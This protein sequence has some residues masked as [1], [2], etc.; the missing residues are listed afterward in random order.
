MAISSRTISPWAPMQD[1]SIHCD[2][3]RSPTGVEEKQGSG[4]L[5]GK[6]GLVHKGGQVYKDLCCFSLEATSRATFVMSPLE[7]IPWKTKLVTPA[8]CSPTGEITGH[9]ESTLAQIAEKDNNN[10][11]TA[12]EA[13]PY[14]ENDK[15]GGLLGWMAVLGWYVKTNHEI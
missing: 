3:P 4:S 13:P 10:T 14:G 5:V 11:G 12:S 7:S 15:D 2:E 8:L 9:S 6:D 1:G